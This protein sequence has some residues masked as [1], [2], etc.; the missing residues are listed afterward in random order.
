MLRELEKLDLQIKIIK[1]EKKSLIY[2]QSLCEGQKP[3][4]ITPFYSPQSRGDHA[5]TCQVLCG[6]SFTGEMSLTAVP[7]CSVPVAP[8]Q[9]LSILPGHFLLQKISWVRDG[10]FI[11]PCSTFP[12]LCAPLYCTLG[13][14]MVTETIVAIK[15]L[16][17]RTDQNP[18]ELL[19]QPA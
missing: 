17:C 16:T 11:Y 10:S 3:H 8:A 19:A 7:T 1:K 15:K 9:E 14:T 4:K 6:T 5:Q 13:I 18:L 12:G 2:I